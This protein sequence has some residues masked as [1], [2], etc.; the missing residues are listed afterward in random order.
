MIVQIGTWV[1]REAFLQSVEW[2]HTHLKPLKLGVNVSPLQLD[3]PG[4]LDTVRTLLAETGADP[5]A[6]DIEITETVMIRNTGEMQAV[7]SAL[8]EM[9]FSISIDD[10]GSGYASLGYLSK[11]PF[12]RIKL[13]KSLIDS[14]LSPV[15]SGALVVKSILDMSKTLGI[16]TIAEGVEKQEQMDMLVSMGCDQLQGYLAGRPVPAGEFRRLF[17][18]SGRNR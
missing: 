2:R 12:D 4:F 13:D 7:F 14:L 3:Q 15:A 8:R 17:I 18:E 1:L 11:F 6:L 5:A 9:G 10:F 16:H